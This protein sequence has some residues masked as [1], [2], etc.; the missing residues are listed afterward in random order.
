M[1]SLEQLVP[2][3][4]LVHQVAKAI[5]VTLIHD[6][7][8]HLY[9]PITVVQRFTLKGLVGGKYRFTDSPY[10]KARANKKHNERREVRV[11]VKGTESDKT[12]K[13]KPNFDRMSAKLGL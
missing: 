13:N 6:E 1:I 5:D 12:A 3:D 9:C 2:Q 4:H 8:P 10:L 7:V 11:K